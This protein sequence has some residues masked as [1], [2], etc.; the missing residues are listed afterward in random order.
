MTIIGWIYNLNPVKGINLGKFSCTFS[1]TRISDAS[2]L[3][4]RTL[5]SRSINY[6][7]GNLSNAALFI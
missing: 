6:R 4:H 7:K 2:L 5:L 3:K 1:C